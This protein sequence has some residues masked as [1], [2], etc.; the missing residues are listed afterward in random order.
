MV[1]SHR[2]NQSDT[3]TATYKAII[4]ELRN[5]SADFDKDTQQYFN[6]LVK[7][8][9][10][11]YSYYV[12]CQYIY[13]AYISIIQIQVALLVQFGYKDKVLRLLEVFGL[14]GIVVGSTSKVK[15]TSKGFSSFTK[16]NVS[17]TKIGKL[18]SSIKQESSD[19]NI[20][21]NSFNKELN[22]TK[23]RFD[24]MT[25][26]AE[27]YSN[28]LLG[29]VEYINAFI[30]KT[31]NLLTVVKALNGYINSVSGT[32]A[33]KLPTSD[34]TCTFEDYSSEGECSFDCG[35]CGESSCSF[36]YGECGEGSCSF[37]CSFD[38]GECGESSCSFDCG[39]CSFD[40]AD[41]G[42][43]SDCGECSFDCGE[44]GC[45]YE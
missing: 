26:L 28:R 2:N 37:Y 22:R 5:I 6:N 31:T 20:L 10:R 3:T 45:T 17:E 24:S 13:K 7:V 9:N 39:E 8:G 41:C 1:I 42:D 14:G 30:D 36:D 23:K 44:G 15:S 25:K 4:N 18:I 11:V 12:A 43:C 40:C 33:Y 16:V 32:E 21:S 29:Y 19:F 35:E 34:L 27:N 38:C